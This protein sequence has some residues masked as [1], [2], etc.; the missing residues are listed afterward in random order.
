MNGEPI[1]LFER[2]VPLKRTAQD[3]ELAGM[4]STING[5]EQTARKARDTKRIDKDEL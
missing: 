4:A 3:V 5:P 2:E 1:E